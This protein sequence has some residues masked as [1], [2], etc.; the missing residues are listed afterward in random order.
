MYLPALIQTLT[1]ECSQAAYLSSERLG[2]ST[3]HANAEQNAK[4]GGGQS[5]AVI[6]MED[7]TSFSEVVMGGTPTVAAQG[8]G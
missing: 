5:C 4:A 7:F 1:L 3:D 2:K 8:R 6:S